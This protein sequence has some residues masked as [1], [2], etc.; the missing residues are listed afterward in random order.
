VDEVFQGTGRNTGYVTFWNS[1]HSSNAMACGVGTRMTPEVASRAITNRRF[2]RDSD[3][4]G[5]SSLGGQP[6]IL[7]I[8]RISKQTAERLARSCLQPQPAVSDE[9]QRSS[10]SLG[11]SHLPASHVRNRMTMVKMTS[12][13]SR[14]RPRAQTRGILRSGRACGGCNPAHGRRSPDVLSFRLRFG[15]VGGV[16]DRH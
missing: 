7:L 13:P 14:V 12:G 16:I 8:A 10:N 5:H 4:R 9:S 11:S 3:L 15:A 6:T 2:I 1:W